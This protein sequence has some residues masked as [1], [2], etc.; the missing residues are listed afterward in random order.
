MGLDSVLKLSA[1]LRVWCTTGRINFSIGVW[2]SPVKILGVL[3]L[4]EKMCPGFTQRSRSLMVAF[5]WESTDFSLRWEILLTLSESPMLQPF[6]EW[7]TSWVVTPRTY[8]PRNFLWSKS[9]S[10]QDLR[11]CQSSYLGRTWSMWYLAAFSCTTCFARLTTQCQNCGSPTSTI[12]DIL[13]RE[14]LNAR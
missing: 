3:S 12:S 8:C 14:S 6:G 13:K 1:H 4:N 7:H 9:T 11:N 5:L 10:I 2:I